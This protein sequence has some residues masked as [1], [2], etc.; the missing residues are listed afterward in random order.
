MLG[1]AFGEREVELENQSRFAVD[2]SNLDL[3]CD[4]VYKSEN[5]KNF[6]L[7]WQWFKVMKNGKLY[8]SAV[9]CSAG[10]VNR[11]NS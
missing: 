7:T 10:G 11:R 6:R 9:I 2:S 1:S 4:F 3:E 5:A 8:K